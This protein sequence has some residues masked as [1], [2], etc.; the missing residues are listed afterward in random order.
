MNRTKLMEI[1]KKHGFERGKKTPAKCLQSIR[2][3]LSEWLDSPEGQ[4]ALAMAPR[5]ML[6]TV[7]SENN[8]IAH[9]KRKDLVLDLLMREF[10]GGESG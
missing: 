2:K 4:A 1:G 6:Y 8:V 9:D 7:D 5:C 3:E 10:G